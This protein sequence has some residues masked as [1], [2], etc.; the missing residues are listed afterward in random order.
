[1]APRDLDGDGQVTL[2]ELYAYAYRKT[3]RR[4][5]GGPAGQHPAFTLAV[6]GA[7]EVVLTRP[8]G[9]RASLELPRGADRYLVFAQPSD[10][11]I[12]DLDGQRDSRIAVPV[13]RYLVARRRGAHS[14]VAL[15]DLSVGGHHRLGER[16]L[17]PVSREELSARGGSIELRRR[18]IA[19]EVGIELA[20][21]AV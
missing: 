13:G 5:L 20:T 8:G 17:K 10:G 1:V 7:G 15:I 3:L 11:V 16:E 9:S 2:T 18:A 4:A 19:P 21:G 14:A 6:A 12:A